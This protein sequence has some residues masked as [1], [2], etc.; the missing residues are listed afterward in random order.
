[1]DK[2]RGES[3]AARKREIREAARA[4]R[5]AQ[6]GKDDLSREIMRRFMGLPEFQAAG[7]VLFYAHV[8]SEVRTLPALPV[9]LR[10]GKRIAIPYCQGERLELFQLQ[11]LEELQPR[12]FGVPE[13]LL[14]L[15]RG[16]GRHVDV[17]EAD[18]ILVP[19]VAFDTRG[20]R[21]GYGKGYYDRL[22][23]QARPDAALVAAAF[24]CQLLDEAPL[25]E[26]DILMDIVV[27]QSAVHRGRGRRGEP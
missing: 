18:V 22:L 27:T 9:A 15:Q 19:G 25:D 20:G 23:A 13:P 6:A 26:H 7:T 4:A 17:A 24:D 11:A 1:M 21:V 10:S 14:D 2:S 3:I 16:P 5:R 8:R 12:R